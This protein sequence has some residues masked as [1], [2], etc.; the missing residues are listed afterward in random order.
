MEE[1]LFVD[2]VHLPLFMSVPNLIRYYPWLA[3]HEIKA[4]QRTARSAN[5]SYLD[6]LHDK[7]QPCTTK[8]VNS[9]TYDMKPFLQSCVDRYIPLAGDKGLKLNHVSTPF[10]DERIARPVQDEKEEK[11]VLAPVAARV[12]MKILFAARMARFATF[13][14]PFRGWL[15]G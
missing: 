6:Q 3:K 9:V 8:P 11:G 2:R 15:Q 10:H 4:R 1:T 14:G 13:S 7:S 12:L 5:F